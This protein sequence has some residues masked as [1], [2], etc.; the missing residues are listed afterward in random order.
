MHCNA[1]LAAILFPF[2]TVAALAPPASQT[3]PARITTAQV[4]SL[5]ESVDSSVNERNVKDVH[6]AL[7][8][9]VVITLK[10]PTPTGQQVMMMDRA[11][12]TAAL[13]Q[14]WTSASE[15]SYERKNSSIT[16]SEDGMTAVVTYEVHERA[17]FGGKTMHSVAKE[18]AKLTV[19][20]MKL[21][22][23]SID[24]EIVEVK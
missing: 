8:E 5:L 24:A 18:T 16:I 22:Y 13:K 23:I 6:D 1:K 15:Y 9:G 12:Y 20:D 11:E 2:L 21:R 14:G 3:E 19:I 7:S 4:Q 17:S 10:V